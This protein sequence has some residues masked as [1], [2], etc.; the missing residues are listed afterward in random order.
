[1]YS[2]QGVL[3]VARKIKPKYMLIIGDMTH[4]YLA[5]RGNDVDYAVPAPFISIGNYDA[6]GTTD[7]IYSTL[8]GS[9]PKVAVG[10]IPVRTEEDL[11]AVYDKI[12]AHDKYEGGNKLDMFLIADDDD[13]QFVTACEEAASMADGLIGKIYLQEDHDISLIRKYIIDTWN[14][15]TDTV[16]YSGHGSVSAWASEKITY[17]SMVN[18]L[19]EREVSPIV[20]HLDCWSNAAHFTQSGNTPYSLGETLML[21]DKKGASAS[22]G[23]GVATSPKGQRKLCLKII[24]HKKAYKSTIGNALLRA[25]K[26]MASEGIYEDVLQSFYLLGDPAMK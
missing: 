21:A 15:G 5:S 6:Y 24:K 25:Q 17:N 16:I 8:G 18:Q 13:K 4:D 23:S 2:Y 14:L 1:M 10:R 12:V 7:Y 20:Y 11:Q 9:T 22:I 19:E 3:N 26:S